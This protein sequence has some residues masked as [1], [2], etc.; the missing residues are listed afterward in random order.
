MKKII[1]FLG[2]TLFANHSFA[3]KFYYSNNQKINLTEDRNYILV[4]PNSEINSYFNTVV[5]SIYFTYFNN[6][7]IQNSFGVIKLQLKSASL[8]ASAISALKASNQTRFVWYAMYI[9]S[10]TPI[11]PTNEILYK[12]K[13]GAT[14]SFASSATTN[15][16]ID[17][18]YKLATGIDNE[19][20][21]NLAN[22]F[23][24]SGNAIW[25]H[26]NFWIPVETH[27]DPQ[28]VNQYYLK[29]TGQNGGTVGIDINV[30]G[31][32]SITQG[33]PNIKV[34]VIDQGVEDHEDLS[35]RV[36]AGYT[37][38]DPNGN[39][40]PVGTGNGH[41]V[42]CAGII[43]ASK[44]NNLDIAGI[45]PLVK[46]VPVNIFYGG[47]T[48]NDL[49]NAIN[50]A[51]NQGQADVLSNSW[52][53][54]DPTTYFDV[55]ANAIQNARTNG[56]SGKGSI[57]VFSSGNAYDRAARFPGN[58]NGVISVG[59]INKSG[60]LWSYSCGG[61]SLDLV[62]P[63][64]DVNLLGD[65]TTLDRMGT[66]GYEA[67]NY[68][69]R[70]GGT[71]AACPEVSG[72]AALM[73]SAN[74]N[75]TETQV[76]DMLHASAIDMGTTGLDN[77]YGYGRLNACGA[78]SKSMGAL[79]ISGNSSFCSGTSVYSI[80]NILTTAPITWSVTPAGI[81]SLSGSGSQ[82]TL[83]QIGNG[84]ITLT[85]TVTNTCGIGVIT[86]TK[87]NIIVGTGVQN[88]AIDNIQ[89][90][91]N[92][93]NGTISLY[94]TATVTKVPVATSYKWYINNVLQATTTNNIAS[95]LHISQCGV[96]YNFKIQ[97]L[98]PCGTIEVSDPLFKR[99]CSGTYGQRPTSADSLSKESV[100]I[101]PNPVI[102]SLLIKLNMPNNEVKSL[103][104]TDIKG[105]LLI[106]Q[107]IAVKIGSNSIN[108]NVSS[109]S[110]GSYILLVKGT[111]SN[112]LKFI[113]E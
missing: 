69:N 71:S 81:V 30:E 25:C 34:A 93:P 56:R 87:N 42:A 51:W 31:A 20:I 63:T 12:A 107:N 40:R 2:I 64:G 80:P 91:P 57:V 61:P 53:Y 39:G 47:E 67:G 86:I 19:Q 46:I 48:T 88:F 9:G 44:D 94:F 100:S 60:G 92:Y 33:S 4:V 74:P 106:Q 109:L 16:N 50:W 96:N 102:N 72:V 99:N 28:Y 38:R 108:L 55:I 3:Q 54:S 43:A 27:T 17:T 23:Y 113:K 62:A 35:G 89:F 97:A 7:E 77:D 82:I 36:L 104:I 73:L 26:P 90:D 18:S 111:K 66:N 37:P 45:A 24:E 110:K 98:T 65:V 5:Q 1:L 103:L 21:F 52:G 59:A 15:T 13:A 10:L 112:S 22:Q 75:L 29:N 11:I 79:S 84:T 70:F 14:P 101:Y 68:T 76:S 83:T 49:A 41:G 85:A 95:G 78:V 58:V 8:G 32:W 6:Y 105:R